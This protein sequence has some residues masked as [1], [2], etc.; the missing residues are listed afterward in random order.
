VLTPA[1]LGLTALAALACVALAGV[2]L[3]ALLLLAAG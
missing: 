3:V 2:G 1:F